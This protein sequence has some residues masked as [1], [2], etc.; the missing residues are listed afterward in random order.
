MGDSQMFLVLGAVVLLSLL[1]INV[2]RT[3]LSTTD[4]SL[5]AQAI[6]TTTS[7][8][9]QTIDVIRSKSFDEATVSTAITNINDFTAPNSF[10]PDMGESVYSFDDVDDYSNYNTI[11]STPRLG[12]VSVSVNVGYVNT[13]L[14]DVVV[15]LKTRMKRIEVKAFSIYMP[16][17]LKLYYYASY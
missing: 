7:V 16:D 1:V 11:V 12:N 14:P 13:N 10:G 6:T 2:N 15:S 8:A 9:Q 17:T 4:N 3:V 5:Q